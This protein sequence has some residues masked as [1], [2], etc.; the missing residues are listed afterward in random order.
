M[1]EIVLLLKLERC[2]QN[3]V[4]KKSEKNYSNKTSYY[5]RKFFKYNVT[6]YQQSTAQRHQQFFSNIIINILSA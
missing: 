1:F 5:N 3:I 4:I 2:N 6:A